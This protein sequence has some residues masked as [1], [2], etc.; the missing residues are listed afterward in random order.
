MAKNGLP[1]KNKTVMFNELRTQ[2]LGLMTPAHAEAGKNSK[3]AA[4]NSVFKRRDNFSKHFTAHFFCTNKSSISW[5]NGLGH[6]P[7]DRD[8]FYDLFSLAEGLNLAGLLID[9]YKNDR[10]GIVLAP[11]YLVSFL[12]GI[13][14]GRGNSV[15][16]AE[17][18]KLVVGLQLLIDA[19]PEKN[20]TLTT[21]RYTVFLLL[22]TAFEEFDNVQVVN[23]SIYRELLITGS[24]DLV[25]SIPAFGGAVKPGGNLQ[26]F[27]DPGNGEHRHREFAPEN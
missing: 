3:N 6:F 4:G 14:A 8:F 18:E 26:E 1:E 23:Q 25:L 7:G 24:F 16:V 19:Y 27:H 15:M 12:S 2:K 13:I 9:S 11:D 20:F 5:E 10:T 21:D 17:T 22:R